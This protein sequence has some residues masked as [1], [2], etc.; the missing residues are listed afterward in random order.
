MAFPETS[1]GGKP[2]HNTRG[3]S[4]EALLSSFLRKETF[5]MLRCIS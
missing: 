1:S 3:I 2:V 5:A 4:E